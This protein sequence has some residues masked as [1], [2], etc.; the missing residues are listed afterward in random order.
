MRIKNRTSRRDW[1]IRH[2]FDCGRSIQ[3]FTLF[4][5]LAITI[6]CTG[7][8]SSGSSGKKKNA[9]IFRNGAFLGATAADSVTPSAPSKRGAIDDGGPAAGRSQGTGDSRNELD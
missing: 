3:W 6:A 4:F 2:T 5:T 9:P 1:A 7:G 8:G